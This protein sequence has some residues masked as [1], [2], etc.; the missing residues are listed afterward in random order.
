LR[1]GSVEKK[2]LDSKRNDVENVHSFF[3]RTTAGIEHL[4]KF[5]RK[6]RVTLYQRT[7]RT[8]EIAGFTT[9]AAT[10]LLRAEREAG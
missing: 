6:I 7:K 4:T 3:C 1:A 10:D 8:S 9:P 5:R 2:V